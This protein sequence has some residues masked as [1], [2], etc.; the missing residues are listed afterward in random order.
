MSWKII[1]I[2]GSNDTYETP[3][4]PGDSVL[5]VPFNVPGDPDQVHSSIAEEFARFALANTPPCEDLLNFAVAA[6]TADVRVPRRG[7]FDSWTRDLELHLFV[8]EMERWKACR[9]AAEELLSFLTGDRWVLRLDFRD[10][11]TPF[12][13]KLIAPPKTAAVHGWLQDFVPTV[14]VDWTFGG[15]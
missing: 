11:A 5:R 8:N 15:R 6:Y 12:P 7:A 2:A 4:G 14:G 9:P 10:Y 13:T 3:V 1:T